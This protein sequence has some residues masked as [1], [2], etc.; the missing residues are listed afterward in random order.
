MRKTF[1]L[2]IC[3]FSLLTVTG[4]AENL[5]FTSHYPSPAGNYQNIHLSPQPARPSSNC[6]I[7]ALYVNSDDNNLLYFCAPNNLG[8]ATFA[9]IAG[10][11]TLS[12]NDLYLTDTTAP[13][14]KKIG[15]G[16]TTPAFK[17]TIENDGGILADGP[18]ASSS[19][20]P[21]SGAGTRLMWYPAKGAFRAGSVSGNQWDDN[22]I[23]QNSVAMGYDNTAAGQGAMIWG[24]KNNS[25]N[26]AT[27]AAQFK[28]P[29]ITGGQNNTTTSGSSQILG[30]SNNINNGS[31]NINKG[32]GSRI[33]GKANNISDGNYS[34]I[35]G[36]E[37]N[38]SSGVGG[39]TIAGGFNNSIAGS[40]T[41][42][43]GGSQNSILIPANYSAISGGKQNVLNGASI[44]S[45]ISGGYLNSINNAENAVINSGNSNTASGYFSIVSSGQS[46]TAS[47]PYSTIHGGK[48][49]R[50]D[51]SPVG[52]CSIN[53]GNTNTVSGD[54]SSVI[55]GN[56][57]TAIGD[58]SVVPGGQ[59]NRASG[60]NSLA[61]GRFMNVTGNHTFV[62]GHA[63]ALIAPI[64]KPDAMII[65]SGSMGIRDTTP[66]ALLE[67]NS[68]ATTDDYLNL[69][70]TS[71]ATAGNILKIRGDPPYAGLIGVNHSAPV[72]PLQF[73]NGAYVDTSGNFMPASSRIYKENIAELGFAEALDTLVKLT[74]VQYNYKNEK[75]HR[76]IGFIAED[77]PDL[78]ADQGRQGLAPMDIAAVLTKIIAHQQNILKEQQIKTDRLLKEFSELKNK[79]HL[80]NQSKERLKGL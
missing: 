12:S 27:S 69:T 72:Y 68:N 77:V 57:N 39:N 67:I 60:N 36:G 37:N 33:Y 13:A 55:G 47:G 64:T 38:T 7:G 58:Y 16:T 51:C 8:I 10:P 14:N 25:A 2:F 34:L 43:S 42:I 40:M 35:G 6:K 18:A 61:A 80:K 70:S 62:W 5:N 53:G 65:Y 56:L 9:P 29:I 19:A 32:L 78:V 73:G 54:Y 15:I 50:T 44:S 1:F 17:L 59:G 76:Y 41:T 63:N 20:L 66:A 52:Y 48:N 45:T 31:N 71:A 22:N 49:N 4:Q 26:N 23:G 75:T 30:G 46:N 24:G 79:M 74:P 3:L 21:V 28:A 11:W